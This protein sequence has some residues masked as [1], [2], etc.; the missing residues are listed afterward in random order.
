[1]YHRW[2]TATAVA[3]LAL[4]STG[5]V[6]AAAVSAGASGAAHQHNVPRYAV[7][8][9]HGRS[10][11]PAAAGLK[12]KNWTFT[13]KYNATTYK[14]VLLGTNPKK[15]KSSTIAVEIIPVKLTYKK[16]TTD[17]LSEIGGTGMNVVESTIASP[18]FQTGIDF[19]QGGTDLGNTQY[20]DAVQRA[21]FWGTVSGKPGYHVLLG[22]PTVEPEVSLTVPTKD[23]TT[24]SPFGTEV[25]EASVNWVDAQI[26]PL[27]TSVP[28]G[29][30]P[31]YVVTNAYMLEGATSGCC[32]GGY[33]SY[34]GSLP[35]DVFS[36]IQTAG[37]FSQD[38]SGLSHEL[39][40]TINDPTTANNSPCGIYEVG[41]PLETEANYGDYPYTLG[42][43]TYHLQDIA[44]PPYFGAP[45]S[46]SVNDWSTFQ[47]TTLSVCQ[48]GS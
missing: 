44:L 15:G 8:V 14:D 1:M 32:I 11:G 17:P 31:I 29:V 5:A 36:Y 20:E 22:Q 30:L 43:M 40:E 27:L 28:T 26:Q 21:S 37:T 33:H 48:N 46:T 7:L 39:A 16:L 3:L 18:L 12:F 10:A 35:Y 6:A 13:Y 34:N 19:D 47:G 9:H 4:G 24:G 45:A 25:I 41:D 23:G 42:A 2:L 38:V